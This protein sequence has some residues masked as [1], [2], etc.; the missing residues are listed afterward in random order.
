MNPK[1][2]NRF[3]IRIAGNVQRVGF[4]HVASALAISNNLTGFACYINRDILIEVEGL[5]HD[6]ENFI[7]WTKTGPEGCVIENYELYEIPPVKSES[8]EIVP[9]ITADTEVQQIAV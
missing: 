3:R 5:F 6:L 4:R 9:G 1:N 8:F 2:T 7:A